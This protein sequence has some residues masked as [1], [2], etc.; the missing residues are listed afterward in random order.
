MI[1]SKGCIFVPIILLDSAGMSVPIKSTYFCIPEA[2]QIA[3]SVTERR[4]VKKKLVA[5]TPLLS[6]SHLS[7]LK[8]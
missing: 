2:R 3:A 8:P 4:R 1:R 6:A 7:E 5:I